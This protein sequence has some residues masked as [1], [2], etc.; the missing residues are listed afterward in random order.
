MKRESVAFV[1]A[2]SGRWRLA[3]PPSWLGNAKGGIVF[4][5]P[6]PPAGR[7]FLSHLWPISISPSGVCAYNLQ[8]LP[9]GARSPQ[10]TGEFLPFG[11]I[12]DASTDGAYLVINNEKFA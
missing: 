7:V 6:F 11:K 2:W 4:L 3:I 12:Q 5:N 8:T 1:S 10:Q 9:F